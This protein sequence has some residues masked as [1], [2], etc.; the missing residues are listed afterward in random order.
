MK[1]KKSAEE[2]GS[3]VR[4]FP[5]WPQVA[6]TASSPLCSSVPQI[7][8]LCPCFWANVDEVLTCLQCWS[9]VTVFL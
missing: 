6:L 4:P 7:C 5:A 3:N 1:R 8:H 2:N 9:P